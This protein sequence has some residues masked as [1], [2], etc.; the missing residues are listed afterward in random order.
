MDTRRRL[1]RV[2]ASPPTKYELVDGDYLVS[3]ERSLLDIGRIHSFLSKSYWSDGVPLEVVARAIENSLP[4]GLYRGAQQVGFARV[5]TDRATFA[6]IADV[7]V[8]PE[9]RGNGLS[10]LLMRAVTDHPDLQG[11]RRWMLG[12]KDAH[13]LYR[14]FGF[15]APR[16]PKRWME[17][18]DPNVYRRG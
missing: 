5:I 2:A 18:A 11:L 1:D 6:Y 13:G 4:F 8:E 3:T 15:T 7:Y 12:T 10:K 16:L 14:Q 17:K 9:H